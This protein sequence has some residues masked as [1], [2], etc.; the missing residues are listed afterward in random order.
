M[1]NFIDNIYSEKILKYK[2]KVS[3]NEKFQEYTYYSDNEYD[4]YI[5]KYKKI[6]N[7]T[8]EFKAENNTS[9]RKLKSFLKF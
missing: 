7:L 1:N 3:F 2:K 9:Y 6:H 5:I 8:S 4:Y